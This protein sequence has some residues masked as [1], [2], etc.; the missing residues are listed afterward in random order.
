VVPAFSGSFS[1]LVLA[2]FVSF[3]P[4]EEPSSIA[5]SV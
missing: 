5:S 1:T 3:L 4:V 2:F